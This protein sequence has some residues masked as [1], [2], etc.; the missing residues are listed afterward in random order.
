VPVLPLA[1]DL[2]PRPDV[3]A[4]EEGGGDHAEKAS[5][6]ADA[7]AACLRCQKSAALCTCASTAGADEDE[8]EY[9]ADDDD[10]EDD[11]VCWKADRSM[12]FC[13]CRCLTSFR[14]AS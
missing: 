8:D 12:G 1:C 11:D 6:G 14:N 9:D 4:K 13:C 2:P 3:P 5:D 7:D 10:E